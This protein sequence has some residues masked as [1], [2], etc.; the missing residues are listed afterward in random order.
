MVIDRLK[1]MKETRPIINITD[2]RTTVEQKLMI[3]LHGLFQKKCF[4]RGHQFKIE[5]EDDIGRTV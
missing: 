3:K 1:V 4:Q 5:I 2:P